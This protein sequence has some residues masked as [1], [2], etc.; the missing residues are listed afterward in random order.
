MRKGLAISRGLFSRPVSSCQR[1]NV[2]ILGPTPSRSIIEDGT[3]VR[4]FTDQQVDD[5]IKFAEK[6]QRG[7]GYFD[8]GRGLPPEIPSS[9]HLKYDDYGD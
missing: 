8:G 5:M 6:E 9:M 4:K 3:K 2:T 7:A 1:R